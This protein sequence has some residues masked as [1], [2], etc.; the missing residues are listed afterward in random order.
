MKEKHTWLLGLIMLSPFNILAKPATWL[1]AT[2]P[3]Q[4]TVLQ[5]NGRFCGFAGLYKNSYNNPFD[6]L[7]IALHKNLPVINPGT[8]ITVFATRLNHITVDTI[9]CGS[10]A[11]G[12]WL[13]LETE[14]AT[15]V[16]QPLNRGTAIMAMI[17]ANNP[18]RTSTVLLTYGWISL[19]PA[20][21][22]KLE[23]NRTVHKYTEQWAKYA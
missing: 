3:V 23:L 20:G 4:N 9:A 2:F 5:Y 7:M 17:S 12:K 8:L 10:R 14:T 18:K 21:K 16:F 6:E 11:R 22:R 15:L 13:F 1:N 19:R